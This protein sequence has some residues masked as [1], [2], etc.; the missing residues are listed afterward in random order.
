M[1]VTEFLDEQGVHYEMSQHRSAFTA[2]QM[3]AEE[4]V[5]GIEVAKPVV[6]RADETY[7]LCVLPACCKIDMDALKAYLKAGQV[8]LA[9]EEELAT[10]FSDCALG[11]EPPFGHLY[12]L[13]TL[14]DETL[15]KD[16]K[17]VFQAG[18]HELAIRMNTDDFI[19]LE[20]PQVTAYSY[21][22]Q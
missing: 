5:P 10:L 21:H 2:Q 9:D 17:I 12:G 19:K 7:Y 4:H 22:M 8:S 20:K 11:A 14:L 1:K 18:T 13:A 3:A 6:I 15:K 16:P